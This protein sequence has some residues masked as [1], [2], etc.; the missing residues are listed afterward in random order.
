MTETPEQSDQL[1][2]EAPAE[3]V[4]DDAGRSGADDSAG[5]PG[6]EGTATGNPEAAGSDE[7]DEE[8]QTG[9]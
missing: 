8:D 9:A 3:Q 4:H 6:E 5:V 1:P 2:E 7:G